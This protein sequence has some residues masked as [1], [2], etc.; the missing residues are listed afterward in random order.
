M[1]KLRSAVVATALSGALLMGVSASSAGAN[2][3]EMTCAAQ[4][5]TTYSPGVTLLPSPQTVQVSGT[6]IRCASPSRPDITGGSVS[7]SFQATRSCLSIDQTT[8]GTSGITWNTG[9]ST[10]YKYDSTTATIAG[11]IVVTISGTVISGPFQR[12]RITVVLASPVVNVLKCLT[13]PGITSRVGV[14]TLVITSR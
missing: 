7:F 10:I 14:G 12:N 2:P 13:P 8:S 6:F 9:E 5:R 11:Q 3:V 1:L 4:Q